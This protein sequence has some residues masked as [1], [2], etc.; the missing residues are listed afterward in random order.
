MWGKAIFYPYWENIARGYE[1][2]LALLLLVRALAVIALF[3][4][5]VVIVV[6]LYRH[7]KWTVRGIVNYL[8][9]KKYDLEVS[10][11]QKKHNG[12]IDNADNS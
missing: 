6:N 8:S 1:D 9:D 12:I 11:N 3:V 5:I 7:K 2:I 10:Y 4:I